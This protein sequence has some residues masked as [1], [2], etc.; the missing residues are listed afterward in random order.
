MTIPSENLKIF[1]EKHKYLRNFTTIDFP[2]FKL[3]GEPMVV[4]N[5][6][7]DNG[8]PID[9]RNINAPSLGM[10][11]LKSKFDL[12]KLNKACLDITDLINSLKGQDNW[13]IDNL[14]VHFKYVRTSNE[15]VIT[16][17]VRSIVKLE[18]HSIIFLHGVDYPFLLKRPV[19][20]QYA[21]VLHYG[22]V[23]WIVLEYTNENY[24]S[25]FKKV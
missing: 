9:D 8:Q 10:R 19:N 17:P 5:L 14:G 4:H 20:A 6:V 7:F 13:F 12:K 15:K 22:P 2:V 21:R 1:T 11:R 3:E 25:T 18:T 23:P 16:Y 24:K